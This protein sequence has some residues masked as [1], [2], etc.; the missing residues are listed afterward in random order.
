MGKAVIVSAVRTISG[1]FGG[2]LSSLSAPDLGAI[3]VKA[4]VERA[5]ISGDDVDELIFGCGWQAGLGP[6][7]ARIAAVKGGLPHKV[8][9]YTINIRCA[10]SLQAVIQ[11]VRSITMGDADVVIAGGTESASNVPYLIPQAR[12]GARMWDFTVNDGLH[13]DGFKCSLA[14]MFM[15]DTAEL[16]AD[17]YNISRDEQDTFA[18]ESHQKA[19][20]AVAEGKFKDEIFPL[21]VA[22]K[23][24]VKLVDKEEI[25][26]ADAS[27]EKMLKL[28]AVFKKDGGTVTA[29][30]SCALSD[31]ASAMVIMSEEKAKALGLVPLA[32][33]RG[34][35]AAGVD[36]KYMGIGPVAAIPLALQKAGLKLNDIELIELNEAFA[37]QYLACEREMKFNRDI[38]NVHGGAIALG[39]PVGATGTK[40]MTTNLY[41]L[42]DRGKTLGLTSA[43][44]GGGQG[45]AVI[46]ERLS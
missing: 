30:N 3:I 33:I 20:K 45:L 11:A 46:I 4:A 5:G 43:C 17:K 34:Y 42:K 7:V 41:A 15:G 29:G 27:L 6:N 21:E 14:G 13:K 2:S 35:A 24:T 40:L 44:V 16:L 31:C 9:A 36:P 22:D 38:V 26:R 8:P 37:A 25:P 23:K 19:V 12:W 32:V 1:S 10:S 18:L 39:H 28:P